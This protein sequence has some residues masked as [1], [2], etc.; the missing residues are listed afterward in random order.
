MEKEYYNKLVRDK[1]PKI[2]KKN[3][4]ECKYYV[5][6]WQGHIESL[7]HK[8]H[9]EVQEFIAAILP[10][11]RLSE[12]ADIATTIMT[13][14]QMRDIP[15]VQQDLARREYRIAYQSGEFDLLHEINQHALKLKEV[16]DKDAAARLTAGI[17]EALLVVLGR[18]GYQLEQLNAR[19]REIRD[20]RGVFDKGYFLVWATK[21]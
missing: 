16:C 13:L 5:L 11:T 9:E 4:G 10:D 18:D 1:I 14:W 17:I 2:I 19:I 6:S 21:K 7:H 12:A 8:I 15:V 20:K 3:G